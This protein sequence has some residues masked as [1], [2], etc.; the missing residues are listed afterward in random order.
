MFNMQ[1]N[2]YSGSRWARK[3]EIQSAA[4]QID[5]SEKKYKAAGLPVSCDG[6]TA[7][8]DPTDTHTVI[9]GATGS[10]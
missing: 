1:T 5:L 9:F 4:M 7:Y 8:I 6:K 3:D 2:S 10:K